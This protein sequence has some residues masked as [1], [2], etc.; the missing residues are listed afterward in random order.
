MSLEKDMAV[1]MKI[2]FVLRDRVECE[3]ARESPGY[4]DNVRAECR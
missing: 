3:G 2:D 4:Y 1:W